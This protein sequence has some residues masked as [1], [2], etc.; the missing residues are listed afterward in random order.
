MD[1][2]AILTTYS[3]AV[4]H[5]DPGH[6]HYMVTSRKIPFHANFRFFLVAC[7]C[8]GSGTVP[9]GSLVDTVPR[10]LFPLPYIRGIQETPHCHI[11]N[12]IGDVPKD[13]SHNIRTY[14]DFRVSV[15][16]IAKND[17]GSLRP[18]DPQ[19]AVFHISRGSYI[20]KLIF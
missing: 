18:L 12:P 19:A 14:T 6:M 20:S 2:S 10:A 1:R 11:G 7:L 9:G 3:G 8:H 16:W 15:R 5:S 17:D 4:Q 13:C